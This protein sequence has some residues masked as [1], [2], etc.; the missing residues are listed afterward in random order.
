MDAKS[1]SI[2]FLNTSAVLYSAFVLCWYSAEETSTGAVMWLLQ[3]PSGSHSQCHALHEVTFSTRGKQKKKEK[4]K[5]KKKATG[6]FFFTFQQRF[7]NWMHSALDRWLIY[8]P[9]Q[10]VAFR[11]SVFI[12]GEKTVRLLKENTSSNSGRVNALIGAGEGCRRL[13]QKLNYLRMLR[14]RVFLELSYQH[15]V[16]ST[17]NNW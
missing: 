1:H 3:N 4:K 6:L 15:T 16:M 8:F 12:S 14:D 7:F 13:F 2:L 17:L 5:K 10:N 9:F 11:G